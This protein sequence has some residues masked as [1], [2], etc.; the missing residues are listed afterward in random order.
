MSIFS[1][2]F[3]SKDNEEQKEE[4]AEEVYFK[5]DEQEPAMPDP[6]D[7]PEAM[8]YIVV[9]WGVEYFKTRSF[10]N[11]LNDFHV[12]KKIP[13]AKN[14]LLNMHDNGYIDHITKISN[15]DIESKAIASKFSTEFGAKEEI[16]L[17]LVQSLLYLLLS[18]SLCP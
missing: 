1:K 14:L 18:N 11:I 8:R 10:I 3:G 6:Q 17:Y 4:I 2:W 16:V 13:A 5:E 15:W 7:L 12:L 9:K